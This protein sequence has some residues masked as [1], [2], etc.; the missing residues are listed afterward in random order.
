[1]DFFSNQKWTQCRLRERPRESNTWLIYLEL[2]IQLEVMLVA[3]YTY[4]WMN[5]LGT[6]SSKKKLATAV[7]YVNSER[8]W[9][10][11][12]GFKFNTTYFPLDLLLEKDGAR[13]TFFVIL[14][15]VCK[16]N[17]AAVFL[18]K[19]LSCYTITRSYSQSEKRVL[20][21]I[22]AKFHVI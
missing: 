8:Q 14:F 2:R 19:Q 1:M 11:T 15:T 3:N 10:I 16:K 5:G 18:Y 20:L 7:Q 22:T 4:L 13:E 21:L 6:E 17:S 9:I 12:Q